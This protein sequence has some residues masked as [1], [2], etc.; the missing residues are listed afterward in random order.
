MI[1]SA[2]AFPGVPVLFAVVVTQLGR[3]LGIPDPLGLDGPQ[4]PLITFAV[5]VL[6]LVLGLVGAATTVWLT[7]PR[8]R[9]TLFADDSRRRVLLVIREA[10][11]RFGCGA[12]L[13]TTIVLSLGFFIF[14]FAG[15][16]N[17]FN[18]GLLTALTITMALV[19]DFL[20]APAIMVIVNKPM[21]IPT[22]ENK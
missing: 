17:L 14:V 8:T 13:V 20:L 15:M 16:N 18:F 1:A 2:A 4:P 22:E 10:R 7:R 12:M 6:F 9:I 11:K 19:A 3:I 21:T 5:I